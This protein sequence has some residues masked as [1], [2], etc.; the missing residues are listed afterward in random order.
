MVLLEMPS[1]LDVSNNDRRLGLAGIEELWMS[2]TEEKVRQG[3]ARENKFI[4]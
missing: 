3:A 2:T 4:F 1:L